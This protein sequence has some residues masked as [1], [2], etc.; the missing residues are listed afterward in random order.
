[1]RIACFLGWKRRS[2]ERGGRLGYAFGWHGGRVGFG[3][4]G[5]RERMFGQ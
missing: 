3:G 4:G 2:G 1:M 5:W